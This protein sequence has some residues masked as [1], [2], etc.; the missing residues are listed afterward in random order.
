MK[1]IAMISKLL[2][3]TH[4]NTHTHIHTHTHT[5]IHA[6]THKFSFQPIILFSIASAL[7]QGFFPNQTR[8]ARISF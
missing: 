5:H 3:H 1:V 6:H 7:F 2:A 8:I 4:T